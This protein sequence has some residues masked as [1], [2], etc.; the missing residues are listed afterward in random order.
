MV[1]ALWDSP[2]MNL[3]S[4][5]DRRFE[6]TWGNP[7][8]WNL[9]VVLP[10]VVLVTVCLYGLR[11]DRTTAAR[12]RTAKGEIVS[13]DTPNHDRFGYQFGVDGKLYTGW[14]IPTTT[15]YQIGQQ[16]LVYYDPVDPNKSQLG[17]F[18]ENGSRIEGPVSFS[19]LAVFGVS[20]YIFLRRR[21]IRSSR[22]PLRNP[23]T[24][25]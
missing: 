15:D 13:H 6:K 17:D 5:F 16:V 8:W 9:V 1:P 11:A 4:S 25:G 3:G 19:L 22:P 21:A 24:P 10:F 18:S 14:A 23:P 20:L 12:E 2:D 7:S